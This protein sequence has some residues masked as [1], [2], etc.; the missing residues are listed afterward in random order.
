MDI[1]GD[2]MVINIRIVIILCRLWIVI[3][4]WLCDLMVLYPLVMEC[5]W[6]VGGLEHE[7]IMTFHILGIVTPT[8]EVHH[9]SEGWLNH[10]PVGIGVSKG[11]QTA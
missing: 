1:S 5:E 8:D 9:F 10:Q 2:L 3:I 6:L 7:W 11:D 4:I